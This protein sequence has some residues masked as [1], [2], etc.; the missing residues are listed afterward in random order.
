[1]LTKSLYNRASLST[2]SKAFCKSMNVA[3]VLFFCESLSLITVQAE[4]TWSWQDLPD[5]KPFCSST[6]SP[7]FSVTCIYSPRGRGDNPWGQLFWW[8]Q[9]G[10]ITLF[11][12]CMFQK[13]SLPSYLCTFFHDFIYIYMILYIHMY[14]YVAPIGADNPLGPKFLCQ[15]K[16]LITLVIFC[17]FQKNLFNLW[18]YTHLFMI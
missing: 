15:Q 13:T 4:N 12:G 5:R 6:K 17:N 3:N 14:M 8:K 16:G 18:F 1:M 9:K 2:K 10:L 11:S 7:L